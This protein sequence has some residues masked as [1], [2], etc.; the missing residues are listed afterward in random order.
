MKIIRT[1]SELSA[2]PKGK[3]DNRHHH[4]PLI[5]P[6]LSILTH[7]YQEIQMLAVLTLQPDKADFMYCIQ[8]CVCHITDLDSY[9]E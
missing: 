7:H 2:T 3:E 1:S 4:H 8:F 9:N 6:T 5:Y